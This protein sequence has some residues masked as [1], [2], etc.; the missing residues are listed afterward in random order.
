MKLPLLLVSLA[1]ITLPAAATTVVWQENFENFD[2]NI[3]NLEGQG[4]PTNPNRDWLTDPENSP[5]FAVISTAGLGLPSSFGNK[6][7]AVGGLDPG[8]AESSYLLSPS[9][10]FSTPSIEVPS[11][12]L[13][14]DM[15]FN[16]G[17][18]P[19]GI[20]NNFRLSFFDGELFPE[21][22]TLTFAPS[23]NAGFVD[24]FRSNGVSVFNTQAL[25]PTNSAF[26]LQILISPLFNKWS[27]SVINATGGIVPLF[28]NVDMTVLDNQSDF[29]GFSI[30]WLENG[31]GWG[32]NTLL[33][34]NIKFVETVPEP[35][36]AMLATVLASLALIRRRR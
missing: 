32:S 28:A 21:L 9:I 17:S 22:A 35:G 4:D 27:A 3:D 34:D 10:V 20:T 12:R 7:L 33:V 25:I 6:V 16:S 19:S 31:E 26:T 29:G 14:L 30:D 24:L 5:A 18:L 15:V 23:A 11:V 36:T 8:V 1:S 2:L 13:S